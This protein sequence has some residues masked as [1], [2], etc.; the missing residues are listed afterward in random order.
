MHLPADFICETR[1]V[2]GEQRFNRF[3]AAFDED[4]PVSIRLNPRAQGDCPLCASSLV[5]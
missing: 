5:S 3:M 2:M 4:A 1:Q